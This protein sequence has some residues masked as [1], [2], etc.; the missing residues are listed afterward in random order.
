[1][2]LIYSCNKKNT[3]SGNF[4]NLLNAAK[5]FSDIK[6]GLG[7]RGYEEIMPFENIAYTD[8]YV[9]GIQPNHI[10]SASLSTFKKDNIP[11]THYNVCFL[12]YSNKDA[13]FLRSGLDADLIKGS[14]TH[15]IYRYYNWYERNL[16]YNFKYNSSIDRNDPKKIE[17]LIDGIRKGYN[18]KI[19]FILNGVNYNLTPA[20]KYFNIDNNPNSLSIK[21]TPF[22][23][24]TEIKKNKRFLFKEAIININGDISIL[25]SREFFIT[26]KRNFFLKLFN[27]ATRKLNINLSLNKKNI[28]INQNLYKQDFEMF[29]Y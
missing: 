3:L 24:I 25:Q 7:A 29:L 21:T 4:E 28:A 16:N 17:K 12:Y 13:I 23:D 10:S 26:D 27:Y 14:F 19:R 2:T 6:I 22:I 15:N 18:L 9:V 11:T 8:D 1:M 20:I 5:S